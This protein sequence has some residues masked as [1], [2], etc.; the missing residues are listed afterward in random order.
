MK[1]MTFFLTI[2]RSTAAG[3][4]NIPPASAAR[5]ACRLPTRL[6]PLLLPRERPRIIFIVG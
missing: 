3:G 1:C 4:D 2:N 5:Y 6:L